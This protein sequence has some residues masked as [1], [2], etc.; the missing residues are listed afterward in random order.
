MSGVE[1]GTPEGDTDDAAAANGVDYDAGVSTEFDEI[2]ESVDAAAEAEG[3]TAAAKEKELFE[4]EGKMA[5]LKLAAE[6]IRGQAA[7]N[8][9]REKTTELRGEYAE[10]AYRLA[11]RSI[12]FWIIVIGVE[13]YVQLLSPGEK[14]VLSDP[15]LIAITTGCTVNVLAAFLG[16]IRGLFPSASKAKG[17]KSKKGKKSKED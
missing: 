4:Q 5:Q 7:K 16:V 3:K 11:A 8:R 17:E 12:W 6:K 2:L 1:A 15:V 10:K 14:R 9:D 13:I